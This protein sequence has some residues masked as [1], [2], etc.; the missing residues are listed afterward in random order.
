M[1]RDYVFTLVSVEEGQRGRSRL[2]GFF[3][4]IVFAR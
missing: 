3:F 4:A 2:L 1:L